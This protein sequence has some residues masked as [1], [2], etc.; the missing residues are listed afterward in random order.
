MRARLDQHPVLG[1]PNLIEV[2]TF[3]HVV[4]LNGMVSQGL[5]GREAESVALEAPGVTHV[6]NLLAV[7]H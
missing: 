1:A 4:Y 7:T 5:E 2:Q 3:D 6:V